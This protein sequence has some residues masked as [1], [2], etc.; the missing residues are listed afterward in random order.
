[1]IFH[2]PW[3]QAAAPS[4]AEGLQGT[5]LL[6]GDLAWKHFRIKGLR[7]VFGTLYLDHSIGITG[8]NVDKLRRASELSD[9][10]KRMVIIAGDFNMEPEEWDDYAILDAF[11]LGIV[12]VGS[13]GACKNEQGE[14]AIGLWIGER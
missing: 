5:E 4:I 9:G 10:G 12:T 2:K 1:M 13:D 8:N 3:L 6:E 14:K 7:L 11:G